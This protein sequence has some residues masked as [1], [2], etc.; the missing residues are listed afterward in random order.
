LLLLLLLFVLFLN[1][2]SGSK[3]RYFTHL[4]KKK[5]KL[6]FIYTP[7]IYL[8]NFFIHS[9]FYLPSRS[10]SDRS[11]YHTSSPC[12]HDVVPT[13]NLHLS[14]ATPPKPHPTILLH[15]LE[16]PVF[17]VVVGLFCFCFVFCFILFFCFFFCFCFVL[18]F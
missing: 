13:C 17:F 10:H 8:I 16:P 3:I 5:S 9:R 11:T 7:Y 15:S 1:G 14:P 12:L 18:F 2:F 6:D 4:K